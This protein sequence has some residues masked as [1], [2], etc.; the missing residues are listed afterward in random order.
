MDEI[1]R[2]KILLKPNHIRYGGS[3]GEFFEVEGRFYFETGKPMPETVSELLSCGVEIPTVIVDKI[4]KRELQKAE[5][6]K[7]YKTANIKVEVDATDNVSLIDLATSVQNN[8][9]RTKK[10]RGII[11]IDR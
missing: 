3:N 10:R 7:M 2:R 5:A 4:A 9:V 1:T 6:A 8:G 11:E